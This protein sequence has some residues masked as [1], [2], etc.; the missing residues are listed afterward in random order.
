[1]QQNFLNEYFYI[2]KKLFLKA[3]GAD[4][5][6]AVLLALIESLLGID[7]PHASATLET[8]LVVIAIV[9]EKACLIWYDGL[10]TNGAKLGLMN[11]EALNAVGIPFLVRIDAQTN[12]GLVAP[13]ASET[14]VVVLVALVCDQ[15]VQDGLAAFEAARC[16]LDQIHVETNATERA[17]ILVVER[18]L[19]NFMLALTALE[20]F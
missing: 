20:A 5:K 8:L 1:M 17:A 7:K 12:E 13:D 6:I 9:E 14:V 19:D 10:G 4:K 15:R 16:T 2:Q 3:V 11:C 18:V